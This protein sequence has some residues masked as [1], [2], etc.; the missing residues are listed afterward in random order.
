MMSQK[1][2]VRFLQ[3]NTTQQDVQRLTKLKQQ[4]YAIFAYSH[5]FSHA[6]TLMKQADSHIRT[7][8]HTQPT[9]KDRENIRDCDR[10]SD[11]ERRGESSLEIINCKKG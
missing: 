7:N 10:D 6:H 5:T 11:R 9:E 8:A 1:L 3:E 4:S 2:R